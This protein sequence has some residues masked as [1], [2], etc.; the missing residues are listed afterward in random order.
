MAVSAKVLSVLKVMVLVEKVEYG[1]GSVSFAR[2][3]GL[4]EM[5]VMALPCRRRN[6]VS[7]VVTKANE[8]VQFKIQMWP[9]HRIMPPN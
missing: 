1:V 7:T 4:V 5:A 6:M 9:R 8:N 3:G 2:K